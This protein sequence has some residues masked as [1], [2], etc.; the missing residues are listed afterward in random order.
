MEFHEFEPRKY[1]FMRV[2]LCLRL[3]PVAVVI[4]NVGPFGGQMQRPRQSQDRFRAAEYKSG[5]GNLKILLQQ[6]V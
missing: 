3:L 6:D 1:R 4:I 5:Q 2:G